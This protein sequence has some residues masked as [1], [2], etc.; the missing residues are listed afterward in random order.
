MTFTVE[1][2]KQISFDSIEGMLSYVEQEKKNT[3]R[4]SIASLLAEGATFHDDK[5]FGSEGYGLK[6]NQPAMD[7]LCGMLGFSSP[8]LN[9]LDKSGLASDI[10]ND[11]IKSKALKEKIGNAEF[12]FDEPSQTILGIVSRSYVG[13]SNHDFINDICNGLSVGGQQSLFASLGEYEFKTSY[14]INTHLHIRLQNKNEQGIVSGRG[15]SAKDVSLL[16]LQV[17]N[18]MSGGQALKMA[19]FVERMVCANGLILPVGGS[20]AKLIHSGHRENLAL[21]ES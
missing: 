13:Y 1:D 11:R 10:L 4:I 7:D 14:S 21:C 2:T 20:Q 17:S 8:L 12:V 6:L 3:S 15:G 16:G 18:S 19:Y 5:L 9:K